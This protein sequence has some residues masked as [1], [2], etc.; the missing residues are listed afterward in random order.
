M[1][2]HLKSLYTKVRKHLLTQ[3]VR[4]TYNNTYDLDACAYRSKDGHLSCAVGCLIK[5]EYYDVTLENKA[6][7]YTDVGYA[8]QQSLGYKRLSSKDVYLLM[9]LQDIHD[10][11]RPDTWKLHLDKVAEEF[12]I[13]Q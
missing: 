9:R 2:S 4:S 12:G 3:G 8:V 13:T 7:D 11:K 1:R 10:N 6:A 5:D